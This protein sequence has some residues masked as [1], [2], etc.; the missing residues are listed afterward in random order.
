MPNVEQ[1]VVIS[2]PVSDVEA[3]FQDPENH[4]IWDPSQHGSIQITEGPF[5]VGTR[6]RG[7]SRILGKRVDWTTEVTEYEPNKRVVFT[8]VDTKPAFTSGSTLE[9]IAE[10]TRLTFHLDAESGLGGMFGKLTDPIV[11]RAYSR[12]IRTG[13]DNAAELL[14]AQS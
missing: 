14:A 2:R 10:G 5:G 4:P 12:I 1:S 3:W 13:L 9:D 6:W 7:S 11:T 8:S